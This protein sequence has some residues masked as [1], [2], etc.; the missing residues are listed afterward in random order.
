MASER[1]NAGVDRANGNALPVGEAI[2][3]GA[4]AA[5]SGRRGTIGL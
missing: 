3:V 2:F 1:R 5:M 4:L